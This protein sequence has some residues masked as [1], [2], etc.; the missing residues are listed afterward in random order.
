MTINAQ[1]YLSSYDWP[2]NVRELMYFIE[3]LVVICSE[4]T[5]TREV[6]EKYWEDREDPVNKDNPLPTLPSSQS[7][8][9]KILSALTQSNS[10]IT[11]AAALLGIDRST[12]YR[13]L[14]TYKIEIKKA[15]I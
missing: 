9:M 1:E 3:R 11:K 5:I 8:E 13:K 15:Y 6:I 2:G 10:N 12:L 7:E 14:K 4:Q